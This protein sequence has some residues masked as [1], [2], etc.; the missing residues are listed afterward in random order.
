MPATDA[1]LRKLE[2]ALK[3]LHLAWNTAEG[4]REK[5]SYNRNALTQET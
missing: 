4:R 3:N 1:A 5:I 2:D